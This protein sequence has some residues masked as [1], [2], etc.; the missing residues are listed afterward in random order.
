MLL[1]LTVKVAGPLKEPPLKLLVVRVP[2]MGETRLVLLVPPI[3]GVPEATAKVPENKP[4]PSNAVRLA[5][6][7]AV[8]TALVMVAVLE[9]AE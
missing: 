5:A 9:A 6:E 4:V 3:V 1:V 7:A 2:D 8:M